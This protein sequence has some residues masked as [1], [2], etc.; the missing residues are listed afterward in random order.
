M[1]A[2]ERRARER[3]DM[4]TRILKAARV[5]IAQGGYENL[6]MKKVADHIEY[7]Q[8]ALYNH[9]PDKDSMLLALAQDDLVAFL[10]RA[11]RRSSATPI[12]ALRKYLLSYVDF[13]VTHPDQYRQ[14]FMR[15]GRGQVIAAPETNP[16]FTNVPNVKGREVL[17]RLMELVAACGEHHASFRDVFPVSVFL[18][19]S[20]HGAASLVITITVFPFG[21]PSDYAAKTV[22]YLLS[23]LIGSSTETTSKK[24]HSTAKPPAVV[25]E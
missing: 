6:T 3:E 7:S 24:L 18:W 20:I 17:V 19:T 21:D 10:N 16:E 4:K 22:G 2:A 12:E 9:F 25:K 23:G 15:S 5:L 14:I 1:G 13:A 8:M 11:P